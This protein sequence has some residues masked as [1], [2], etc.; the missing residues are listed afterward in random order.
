MYWFK[1]IFYKKVVPLK[2]IIDNAIDEFIQKDQND[3]LAEMHQKAHLLFNLFVEEQNNV[4]IIIN[5]QT[6]IF[7]VPSEVKLVSKY[8]D[9]LF[10]SRPETCP[11]ESVYYLPEHNLL[12]YINGGTH[13]L[14]ALNLYYRKPRDSFTFAKNKIKYRKIDIDLLKTYF[15]DK[16][17]MILYRVNS[18]DPSN[19]YSRTEL[20]SIMFN[21]LV[22]LQKH[23]FGEANILDKSARNLYLSLSKNEKNY[24]ESVNK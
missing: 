24:I 2:V 3:A 8:L 4:P 19:V 20:K 5:H 15:F 22:T 13:R 21:V 16:K 10:E 9:Y 1:K 7:T 18:G 11:Y 17:R 23:Y 12:C 6:T 14:A